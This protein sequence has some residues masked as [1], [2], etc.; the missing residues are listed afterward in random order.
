M[1]P[2][3]NQDRGGCKAGALERSPRARTAAARLQTTEVGIEP[4]VRGGMIASRNG[5]SS[6]AAEARRWWGQD[7]GLGGPN[8]R[9]A[10]IELSMREAMGDKHRVT[11]CAPSPYERDRQASEPRRS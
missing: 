9:R 3:S 8:S 11:R 2:P 7:P 4:P 10:P 5:L 1:V 6:A